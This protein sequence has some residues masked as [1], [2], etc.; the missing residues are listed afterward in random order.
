[1]T[2]QEWLASLSSADEGSDMLTVVA[3]IEGTYPVLAPVESFDV[4]FIDDEFTADLAII[5]VTADVTVD[6]YDADFVDDEFTADVEITDL[7]GDM[8]WQI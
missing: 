7:D 4:D 2:T 5:T 3:G 8:I 1:M 6:S